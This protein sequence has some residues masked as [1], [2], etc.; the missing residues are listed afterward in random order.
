LTTARKKNEDYIC[1]SFFHKNFFFLTSFTPT[2]TQE[3]RLIYQYINPHPT[4]P[5]CINLLLGDS[6]KFHKVTTN[7]CFKKRKPKVSK[8]NKEY[9]HNN[10]GIFYM[11]A[12]RE[13]MNQ[14]LSQPLSG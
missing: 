2:H 10:G 5:P 4:T 9:F 14:L 12:D 3:E 11:R 1:S 13:D 6:K 8:I 7:I